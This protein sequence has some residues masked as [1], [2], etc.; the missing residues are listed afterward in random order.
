MQIE[1]INRFNSSQ[2]R[3]PASVGELLLFPSSLSRHVDVTGGKEDR[4]SLTFDGFPFEVLGE[5][6]D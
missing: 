1:K 5:K 6:I 3:V 4:V 2:M